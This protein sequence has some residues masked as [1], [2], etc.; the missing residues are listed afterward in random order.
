[1]EKGTNA[2]VI[3]E[4]LQRGKRYLIYLAKN[5]FTGD[6]VVIKTIEAKYYDR[7]EQLEILM[8]EAETGLKLSHPSIIKSL[9]SF[10]ED[11]NLYY[12]MEYFESISL[13]QKLAS[14]S[15]GSVLA[16]RP[17]V[18]TAL[19][20][21]DQILSGLEYAHSLGIYHHKLNPS[22]ILLS[23]ENNIRL[24][25]FGKSVLTWLRVDLEPLGRHPVIY[26]APEQYRGEKAGVAADIYSFGVVAYELL[27]GNV[28]WS[29][30]P[31]DNHLKQKESSFQRP[32][33]DPEMLGS[34]IPHW[35]L[36]ILNKC[37]M[38]EPTLRFGTITELRQAIKD[39]LDLKYL[40]VLT[41]VQA[42][43]VVDPIP[44]PIPEPEPEPI[45]EPVVEPEPEAI[46][47]PV[48]IPEPV[49]ELVPEP[50]PTPEPEP[51]PEPEP[52]L[53]PVYAPEPVIEPEPEPVIEAE[54]VYEPVNTS[55]FIPKPEY[56]EESVPEPAPVPRQNEPVI[57]P[58]PYREQW[59]KP[60]SKPKLPEP[61]NPEE[62]R[63]TGQL[64]KLL[65][66]ASLL[67]V[68]YF[69]GKN[70][71]FR[72][73]P[74]FETLRK[75][76]EEA[77]VLDNLN[78]NKALDMV[79]VQADTVILGSLAPGGEADEYPAL[80]VYVPSFYISRFEVSQE[81]WMMVSAQNP[82]TEK[83]D[84]LP[85]HNVNFYDIVDWCNEKSLMDGYRPCYEYFDNDLSCDFTADGYRLPTE[86]EWEYAARGGSA[87]DTYLYSG[88][89]D[90]DQVSWHSGNS[91][92]RV[93]A[94]GSKLENSLGIFDM[95]GNVAEWVWNWYGPY[96]YQI[97]NLFEGPS[98]GTDRVVRGG[99]WF[100][101][102]YQHRISNRNYQKPFV[103][104]PYI[105]FRVVRT[106][107]E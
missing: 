44:E 7:E 61:E 60:P 102:Q 11:R 94:T 68:L 86:A 56:I 58:K 43:P 99:S 48:Y 57:E 3:L 75:E 29:L 91:S 27:T 70:V 98:S 24:I 21:L 36:T 31:K 81:E 73:K 77:K 101:P 95:S 42:S 71:V 37:L 72:P 59:S 92:A 2:F 69:V 28:P 1:M 80:R 78:V 26:I 106:V 17:P 19:A 38:L 39:E 9:S 54:P 10:E 96:S 13:E 51:I 46:P 53:E 25:G 50:E 82:S 15:V 12:V 64:F 49:V 90:I 89:D 97:K 104:K 32:V 93:R 107:V 33:L 16:S 47:E 66:V 22:N 23:V 65:L 67:V 41:K 84:K 74:R 40:S 4:T 87:K 34:P 14:L 8:N 5:Y 103:Q 6:K 18:D 100:E 20:M 30:N 55:E 85:V 88:S 52:E 62:L 45:P 63:K 76:Q 79:M 105:G 83:G 35:L